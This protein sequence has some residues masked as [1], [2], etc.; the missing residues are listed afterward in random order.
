MTLHQFMSGPRAVTVCVTLAIVVAGAAPIAKQEPV[1][2]VVPLVAPA[3]LEP[4]LP[5]GL[6]GWTTLRVSSNRVAAADACAWAFAEGIYTNGGNKLRVTIADTG[7]D[8]DALMILATIVMSFPAGHT[9]T[10]GSDTVVT[11]ITY[12]DSPAATLWNSSKHEAEFTVVV[13]ERFVAK[14]EGTPADSLDLLKTALD[15]IDLKKLA[16]LGR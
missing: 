14:V 7:F 2:K 16:D 5:V 4:L 3:A 9:E 11:R 12:A 1:K 6:E 13:G 8:S 15:K 10:I